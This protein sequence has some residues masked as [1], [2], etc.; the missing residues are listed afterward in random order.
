MH[1]RDDAIQWLRGQGFHAFNRTW[2]FG[3][4][5]VAA[6]GGEM[7]EVGNPD[8]VTPETIAVW[9]YAVCIYPEA[10]SWSVVDLTEPRI[11]ASTSLS[12]SAAAHEAAALLANHLAQ[13][14]PH[15]K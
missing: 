3:E 5:I 15:L 4:S 14:Q 11:I 9:H 8:T 7:V 6:A 2:A 10:C 12:L 13:D 1:T